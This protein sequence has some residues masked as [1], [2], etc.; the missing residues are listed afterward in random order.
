MKY[1]I[2]IL[3]VLVTGC[4]PEEITNQVEIEEAVARC[5]LET[6][7]TCRLM[8]LPLDAEVEAWIL[9]DSRVRLGK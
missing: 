5:E 7:Q 6:R 1:L 9:Y 4:I 3:A 8:P 2:L